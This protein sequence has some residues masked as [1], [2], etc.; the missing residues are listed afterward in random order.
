MVMSVHCMFWLGSFTQTCLPVHHV[1][2]AL[3]KLLMS[4]MMTPAAA[5]PPVAVAGD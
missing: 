4:I 5:S 1:D 3:L 2:E